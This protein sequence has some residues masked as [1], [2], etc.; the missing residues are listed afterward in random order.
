MILYITV[1]L[2]GSKLDSLYG[3]FGGLHTFSYYSPESKLI[4]M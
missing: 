2:F 4:W 1:L 3:A